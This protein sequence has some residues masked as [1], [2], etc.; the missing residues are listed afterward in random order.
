[1]KKVLVT[2]IVFLLAALVFAGCSQKSDVIKVGVIMPQSGNLTTYGVDTTNAIRMAAEEYNSMTK[3]SKIK[4]IVEDDEGNP[5]KTKAAYLKLVTQDEVAAIVGPLTSNC[6]LAVVDSA[7]SDGVPLITPTATNDKVTEAGDF[8][9]RSCFIDSFQGYVVAKFAKETLSA[10]KAAVLYDVS[11]DYSS[12]IANNFK[13]S[14]SAM[15][16]E[17]VAFESYQSGDKDFNAQITKIAATNPDVLFV[18]DYYNTVSLI[19]KQ[20]RSQ[21]IMVPMLGAD[22]WDG[23]QEVAGAEL[24]PG[25][26]SNHYS[27]D[28]DDADVKAFVEA[29]QKKY[30]KVPSALAALGYDAMKILAAAIEKANSTDA[31]AIKKALAETNGK[32]VTG[33][34]SFDEKHNPIKSAVINEVVPE[35]DKLVIKYKTT[36]NP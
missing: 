29:Y 33:Q 12:G 2:A 21:G 4:L 26:F 14:F 27:P 5:E 30:D 25:Y 28:S 20:V 23:I 17:I 18:P 6:A 34:V 7:Q 10:K 3:G 1:M 9:F 13:Q 22:G 15:G 36:V 16:G 19:A 32:F 35:G 24:A 8:I 11:N 31:E